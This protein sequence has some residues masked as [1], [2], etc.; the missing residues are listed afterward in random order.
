MTALETTFLAYVEK[1]SQV[2]NIALIA[3]EMQISIE[4]AKGILGSLV[5]KD[6]VDVDIV[7]EVQ[8]SK[9]RS[10]MVKK[11]VEIEIIMSKDF[12]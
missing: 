10:G 9:T 5:K 1:H 3:T 12:N 11:I 7:N 4:K 2:S 6:L 8:W